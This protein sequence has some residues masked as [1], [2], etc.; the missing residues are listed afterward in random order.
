MGQTVL[1]IW[2]VGEKFFAGPAPTEPHRQKASTAKLI[3][4]TI[5]PSGYEAR[6]I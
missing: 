3:G 5:P 6:T 2:P 1:C 4:R